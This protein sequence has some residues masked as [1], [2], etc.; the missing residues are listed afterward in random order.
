MKQT[1]FLMAGMI[2][3]FASVLKSS[4][5]WRWEVVYE[6]MCYES[7]DWIEYNDEIYYPLNRP[8][9]VEN[10]NQLYLTPGET[11]KI[12]L[13]RG[14][15]GALD[16]DSCYAVYDYVAESYEEDGFWTYANNGSLVEPSGEY[17]FY[18]IQESIG[19]DWEDYPDYTEEELIGI[20]IQSNMHFRIATSIIPLYFKVQIL[21]YRE[22]F[23]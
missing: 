16:V 6:Y 19:F 9:S 5:E 12:R 2:M 7:A 23:E 10:Y 20:E 15:L 3:F 14:S 11:Y 21:E 8:D 17:G 13:Y 4:A 1:K 22:V 18:N